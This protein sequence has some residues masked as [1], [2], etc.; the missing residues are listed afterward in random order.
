M[1]DLRLQQYY[2]LLQSNCLKGRKS[3]I[4]LRRVAIGVQLSLYPQKDVTLI[5]S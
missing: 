1:S 4:V 3:V 2:T 5:C